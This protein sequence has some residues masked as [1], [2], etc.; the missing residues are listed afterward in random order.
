MFIAAL[1][2]DQ[3]QKK[4]PPLESLTGGGDNV[5]QRDYLQKK[6]EETEALLREEM[7]NI[8]CHKADLLDNSP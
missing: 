6:I 8:Q 7:D 5:I 1:H 2:L 4:L 3:I